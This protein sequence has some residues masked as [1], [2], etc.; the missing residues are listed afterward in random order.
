MRPRGFRVGP[1]R[2]VSVVIPV[3]DGERYLA[4]AIE[5]VLGQT[6]PPLETI[7]V[8]DGSTDA[9][10]AVAEHYTPQVKVCSGPNAGIR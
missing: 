7:V 9:S 2:P 3:H 1:E 4:E 10:A 5:S 6:A 8:D